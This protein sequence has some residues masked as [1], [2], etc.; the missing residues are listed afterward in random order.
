MATDAGYKRCCLPALSLLRK[1]AV[2]NCYMHESQFLNSLK[3]RRAEPHAFQSNGTSQHQLK[4]QKLDHLTTGSQPTSAY[5][6]NL[7]KIWLTKSALRELSRRNS[8]PVLSQPPS[9]SRRS[10]RPITRIYLAEL[11]SRRVIQPAS[12]F[13]RHCEPEVSKEIKRFA[14]HGGPDLSDLKGV[15]I[16]KHPPTL[17]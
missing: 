17:T 3:R 8:Q 11:R 9:L 14:R 5:W 1:S 6:D 16:R 4:R 15:S 13:L 10:R 2:D 12:D 7:S